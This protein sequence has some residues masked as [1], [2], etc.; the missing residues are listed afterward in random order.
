M[1]QNLEEH[2]EACQ[3]FIDLTQNPS[4]LRLKINE[5]VLDDL[6]QNPDNWSKSE[7]EDFK[8]LLSL[9]ERITS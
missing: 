8:L 5:V 6:K 7:L 4:H 9:L 2:A 3:D 1:T